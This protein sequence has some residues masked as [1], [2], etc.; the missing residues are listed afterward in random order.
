MD[1][2]SVARGQHGDRRTRSKNADFLV[3]EARATLAVPVRRPSQECVAPHKPRAIVN[4]YVRAVGQI[5]EIR[6][7]CSL[8]ARSGKPFAVKLPI[9][10]IGTDRVA[11][12]HRP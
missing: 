9:D 7:I 11:V 5:A 12:T 1:C 8:D 4:D 10:D 2:C 3:L 6:P